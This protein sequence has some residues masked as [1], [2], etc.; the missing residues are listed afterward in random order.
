MKK[1]RR[2]KAPLAPDEGAWEPLMLVAALALS[3][4]LAFAVYG[5]SMV[6]GDRE[7]TAASSLASLP[8]SQR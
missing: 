2:P 7:T 3:T 5:D 8:L 1:N 6:G 4:A